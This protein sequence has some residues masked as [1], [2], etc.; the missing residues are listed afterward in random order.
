MAARTA[1]PHSTYWSLASIRA[2]FTGR[3]GQVSGISP[4]KT[5]ATA[6]VAAPPATERCRQAVVAVQ[7]SSGTAHTQ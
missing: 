4:E 5:T 1:R 7:I 2:G 3:P 6:A